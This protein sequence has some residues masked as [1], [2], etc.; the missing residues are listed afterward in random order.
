MSITSNIPPKTKKEL[1]LLLRKFGYTRDG[2][3]EDII[4]VIMEFRKVPRKQAGDIKTV[5]PQEVRE[6]FRILD[7]EYI[8]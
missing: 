4:S 3:K 8:A 7:Y 5:K 6:L 1:Q 2:I